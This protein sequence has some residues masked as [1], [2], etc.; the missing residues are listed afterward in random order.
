MSLDIKEPVSLHLAAL[1]QILE[2]RL[3]LVNQRILSGANERIQIKRREKKVRW[4]LP[5]SRANDPV[6]HPFFDAIQQLNIHKVLDFVD[7]G[8]QF[9]DCFTH[10]SPHKS[11]RKAD[12]VLFGCLIAWG[13]N[14]GLG[15]MGEC[16]DLDYN[17]LLGCSNSFLRLETLQKANDRISDAISS[18]P[19]F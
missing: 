15:R 17:A 10:I 6:N 3:A 19:I 13:T 7:E 12:D 4:T 5:Y 14:M 2:E 8:C 11:R 16:S 18:Q 1:E 9:M